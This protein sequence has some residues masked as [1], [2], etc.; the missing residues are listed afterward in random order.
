MERGQ[1]VF[2]KSDHSSD[3]IRALEQT[4]RKSGVKVLLNTEVKRIMNTPI[5]ENTETGR[6]KAK[7]LFKGVA[8]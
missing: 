1:R 4:L 7:I 8:D 2:P 6:K 3:I 5:E